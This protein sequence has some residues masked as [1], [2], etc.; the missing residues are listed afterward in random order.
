ML[1]NLEPIW[2]QLQAIYHGI[3]WMFARFMV[4][5]LTF[6]TTLGGRGAHKWMIKVSQNKLWNEV[7]V[8]G[9]SRFHHEITFERQVSAQWGWQ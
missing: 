4:T 5:L 3:A 6:Q 8:F 1:L 2:Q 9:L 7:L